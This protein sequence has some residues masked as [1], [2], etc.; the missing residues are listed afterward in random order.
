MRISARNGAPVA[1]PP[2]PDLSRV[3]LRGAAPSGAV[4]T[5]MTLLRRTG[6]PWP[7]D[8]PPPWRARREG[9][10]V[11]AD[12]DRRVEWAASRPDLGPCPPAPRRDSGR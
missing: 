3:S 5:V 1:A 4:V 12:Q 8:A 2:K 10:D 7:A 11:F 6:T 9:E